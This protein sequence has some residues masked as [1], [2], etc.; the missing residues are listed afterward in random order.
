[1]TLSYH[2][3]SAMTWNYLYIAWLATNQVKSFRFASS[4]LS[5]VERTNALL[6]DQLFRNTAHSKKSF[7]TLYRW[8]APNL[9]D[10]ILRIVPNALSESNPYAR[11]LVARRHAQLYVMSANAP[12]DATLAFH[13]HQPYHKIKRHKMVIQPPLEGLYQDWTT[14]RWTFSSTSPSGCRCAEDG[15]ATTYLQLRWILVILINHTRWMLRDEVW[16]SI[17]LCTAAVWADKLLPCP[18]RQSD[19]H[20]F[21]VIDDFFCDCSVNRLIR[22]PLRYT[23]FMH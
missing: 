16:S 13:H 14:Q 15:S 22:L 23:V 2:G 11:Q 12:A 21:E 1:M 6:S 9:N 10:F 4:F 20:V 19:T 7:G 18:P 17:K 3:P 8:L 5:M